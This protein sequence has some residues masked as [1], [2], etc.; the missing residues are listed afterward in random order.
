VNRNQSLKNAT[1]DWYERL[2]GIMTDSGKFFHSYFRVFLFAVYAMTGLFFA[3]HRGNNT[4]HLIR[5][6][7]KNQ[8]LSDSQRDTI[9]KY[10]D[11]LPDGVQVAIAIVGND[12]ITFIGIRRDREGLSY[13]NNKDSVFETGSLTKVFTAALLARLVIEGRLRLED[14]LSA[15]FP[16]HMRHYPVNGKE[17][18]IKHLANHTS[19]LP[20]MPPG[21]MFHSYFHFHWD[22][23]YKDFNTN[24]LLHYL[25]YDCKPAFTPGKRYQ[26]SNL[27]FG[28]LGYILEKQT[29]KSYEELL[30][31]NIF[32][33]L[34]MYSS[35]TL[36]EN[37]RN[38]I[39]RGIYSD[40]TPAPV[41]EMNAMV[42]A[43]GIK[44]TAYDLARFVKAQ[45]PPEDSS[46]KL[47]REITCKIDSNNYAGLGWD[48]RRVKSGALWFIRPGGT[49]G[50]ECCVILDPLKKNAVI[51]LSNLSSIEKISINI[52]Y[53]CLRLMETM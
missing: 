51:V 33:P 40:G 28:I 16:F 32:R 39:A 21:F 50:Y 26:Y 4:P 22:E 49:R 30:Q 53:M 19:G 34:G 15:F 43:G 46:F 20:S 2:K 23:P 29:G 52:Q 18:T 42:A 38:K 13:I 17:I 3:C 11:A 14:P 41:W 36:N 8:V 24:K 5:A 37:V 25:K 45:F 10:F 1:F 48:I 7:I 31:E 6:L 44:S 47:I 12:S 9:Q 35:T 27:G